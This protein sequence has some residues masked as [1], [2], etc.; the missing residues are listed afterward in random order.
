VIVRKI[1]LYKWVIIKM[2]ACNEYFSMS[3]SSQSLTVCKI[4]FKI[5][6]ICLQDGKMFFY[7]MVD[8]CEMLVC[9]KNYPWCNS[10]CWYVRICPKISLG[11]CANHIDQSCLIC[12]YVENG[13]GGNLVVEFRETEH[14]RRL[15]FMHRS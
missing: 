3:D 13:R 6:L 2:F 10:Q 5:S 7:Y 4:H 8:F 11:S 12:M 15:T 1:L 9:D 14:K